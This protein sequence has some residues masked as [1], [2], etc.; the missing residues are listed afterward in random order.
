MKIAVI[1]AG[2][3]GCYY[4]GMLG[5]AGHDVTLIGRPQH[6]DAIAR[7]GLRLDAP[8]VDGPVRLK[9][10]T[11]PDGVRDADLVLFCVKSTA[12]E[13]AGRDLLPFLAPH[14]VVLTL[15]NGVDNADRL[16]AVL[17]DHLVIPT[18]VYVATEMVGPGHVRHHGR[19]ELVIG[20]SARSEDIARALRDAGVR[21]DVS[22]N[23]LGALWE[24]LLMNCVYNA[25]SALS[26]TPY[27]R[28]IDGVEVR[29]TLRDVMEECL[30]VAAAAGVRTGPAMWDAV[31]RIAVTMPTQLSSTAQ[32]MARGRRSEIDHLNG[33]VVRKGAELGVPTPANRVL[34]A[35]VKLNEAR[36]LAA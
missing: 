31:E 2:A 13:S 9:A 7:D 8:G 16:Q 1:G 5:R 35:L 3:V 15:Q 29:N 32:D 20:P 25:M 23:V 22:D 18:V 4:G 12:T 30:A 11:E 27:G 26:Q 36:T 24:K 19:G 6:V 17:P 21:T 10:T 33:Y 34:F 28:L 14:A